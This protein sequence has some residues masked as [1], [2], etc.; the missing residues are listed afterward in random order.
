MPTKTWAVGEEVLAADFNS[1]VQRQV[2]ATFANA[3][4]RDAAIP[5]PTA[6]MMVWLTDISALQV[7]DGSAWRT[8]PRGILAL[9]EFTGTTG[10]VASTPLVIPQLGASVTLP[11]G[12]AIRIEV[13]ATVSLVNSVMTLVRMYIREGGTDLQA[14]YFNVPG[15]GFQS[16]SMTRVLRPTAGTHTYDIFMSCDA[17]SASVQGLG[18]VAHTMIEDLG[19]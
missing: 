11:A 13:V 9:T 1:Y 15:N 16:V 19:A 5:T 8:L 7:R 4:A 2:V 12:R 17:G 6:G 10:S 14:R 18:G 3:A